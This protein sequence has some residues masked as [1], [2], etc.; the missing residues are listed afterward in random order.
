[1]KKALLVKPELEELI[2]G[3]QWSEYKPNLLSVFYQGRGRNERV[4]EFWDSDCDLSQEI[5]FELQSF[6][7]LNCQ[8]EVKALQWQP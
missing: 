2:A 5:P 3:F 4:V 7:R 8:S 6:S 1:M